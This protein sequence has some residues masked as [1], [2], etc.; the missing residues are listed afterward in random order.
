LV[1]IPRMSATKRERRQEETIEIRKSIVIDVS[2]EVIFK[3][4]TD[5]KELTQR[6]PEQAILESKVGG[7]MKF[8]F[9]KEKSEMHHSRSADA[10]PEGTVKKFIPNKKISYTWQHKDVPEFPVAI[11]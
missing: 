5:P 10:S 7:K 11:R 6:F 8:R 1:I 2:P 4:I 9:Y 3:A